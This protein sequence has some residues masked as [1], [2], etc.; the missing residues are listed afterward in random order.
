MKRKVTMTSQHTILTIAGFLLIAAIHARAGDVKIIANPSVK[1][2]TITANELRSVFLLQRKILKDG[3]SVEPVLQRAGSTHETFLQQYLNRDSEEV[4]IYYQGLVFT[5]KAWVPKQLNSDAEVVAYVART[6][7]AIGYVSDGS[8]TEGVKI[9][10]VG[11]EDSKRERSLL[12]RVEPEYPETLQRL[13]ISGTVR[14]ELTISP[15]GN[16]EVVMVVGGNPILAENA[17]KAAKQWIYSPASSHST[18]QVIIPFEAK[19]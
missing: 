3:S 7:G 8:S 11:S 6:R 4:R 5:G 1:T 16:V 19:P 12:T 13:H 18:V 15:K 17:V 10:T 14:L 2:N 9:L